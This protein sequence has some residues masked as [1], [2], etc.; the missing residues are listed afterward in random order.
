VSARTASERVEELAVEQEMKSKQLRAQRLE[1]QEQ[2][3]R[4]EVSC[5]F[6]APTHLSH[7]V[8]VQRSCSLMCMRKQIALMDDTRCD[9]YQSSLPVSF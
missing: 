6:V 5:I 1:V 9:R 3:G 4:T 8:L 7:T 2:A